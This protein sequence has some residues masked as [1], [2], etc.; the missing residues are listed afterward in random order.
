MK[1][2]SKLR[3]GVYAPVITP[4]HDS[5]SQDIDFDAYKL[6][7]ARLA[8]A[9][10]FLVISGTLGEAPLLDREERISLVQTAHDV[11]QHEGLL[12]SIPI[13]AGIGAESMRDVVMYAKDAA[14][15]GADAV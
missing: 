11:L 4:F 5:K 8:R 1:P 13:V 2:A 3:P 15:A 10:I 7:V 12:E 6:N 14:D 9:G